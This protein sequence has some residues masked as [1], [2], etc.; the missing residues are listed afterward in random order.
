MP[1]QPIIPS[2]L[3]QHFLN[4]TIGKEFIYR[5]FDV[6]ALFYENGNIS[7]YETIT[8]CLLCANLKPK[9]VL[10][11]GTFNGRTT[12][13]IAANTPDDTLI[14]TVD[15]PKDQKNNTVYPLEG[16]AKDDEND[17]LGYVG[18]TNKIFLH[19]EP[20][21]KN[22]I[23]QVW[24]DTALVPSNEALSL[25]PFDFIFI[26]ASHKYENVL[27]DSKNAFEMISENGVILWHDYG[28][29]PGVTQALNDIYSKHAL[30]NNFAF[31]EGSS[32]VIYYNKGGAGWVQTEVF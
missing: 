7:L 2:K 9:Y 27:N 12:T 20:R 26:D 3:V 11:Y 1:E 24:M 21:I 6:P 15:L 25:L 13:N 28:G 32:L 14:I 23:Q 19:K 17:E 31:I 22:K 4:D 29:W 18:N 10:E 30:K 8:I 5:H 16:H